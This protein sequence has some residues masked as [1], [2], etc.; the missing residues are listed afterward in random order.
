MDGETTSEK[1]KSSKKFENENQ[2]TV[3][4]VYVAFSDCLG[5]E[6]HLK[7]EGK[8]P[9]GENTIKYDGIRTNRLEIIRIFW[10]KDGIRIVLC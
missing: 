3:K 4:P 1:E 6:S 10:N 2:S 7:A 5:I 9:S 8:E